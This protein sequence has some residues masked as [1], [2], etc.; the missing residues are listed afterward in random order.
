MVLLVWSGNLQLS[1]PLGRLFF[2]PRYK[3]SGTTSIAG[4]FLDTKRP[5]SSAGP[6]LDCF[7]VNSLFLIALSYPS[8][9]KWR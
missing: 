9:Q 7:A 8:G 1:L 2:L 5:A 4:G 6:F 3:L